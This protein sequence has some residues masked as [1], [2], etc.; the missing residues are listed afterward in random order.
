MPA[1]AR[2]RV[3]MSPASIERAVS[4]MAH[5]I[6]EPEEAQSGLVVIGIRRGGESLARRL[7]TRD[8][9]DQQRSAGSRLPQH[10]PLP[11]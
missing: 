8:H 2:R 9:R 10:Q 1:L 3:L 5:Q 11:R 4:R 6:I 7:V